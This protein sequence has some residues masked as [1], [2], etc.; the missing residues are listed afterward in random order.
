LDKY[1]YRLNVFTELVLGHMA[2]RTV[3]IELIGHDYPLTI[4]VALVEELD[5]V[6]LTVLI[7]MIFVSAHSINL[8]HLSLLSFT[9][10]IV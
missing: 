9:I 2:V 6:F 7:D 5:V 10:P 3:L 4:L 1:F 8:I